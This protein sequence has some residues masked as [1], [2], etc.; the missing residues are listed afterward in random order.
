MPRKTTAQLQ[1]DIDD[2]AA[3]ILRIS[4]GQP[5]ADPQVLDARQRG[6]DAAAEL[7]ARAA[8][9]GRLN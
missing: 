9:L 5:S 4:G 7:A 2:A 8:P 1:Q 6:T 3:T